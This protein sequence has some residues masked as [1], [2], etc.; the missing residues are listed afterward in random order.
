M[1]GIFV[2]CSSSDNAIA[3]YGEY[4]AELGRLIAGKGYN[5]VFGGSYNGLMGLVSRVAANGGSNVIAII[6]KAYANDTPEYCSEVISTETLSERKHKMIEKSASFIFLPGG[7]GSLDEIFTII[8]TKRAKE[9]NKSIIIVNINGY[10][11]DLIK[12]I[13]SIVSEGF[14][15][16]SDLQ[17]FY[18]TDNVESAVK[19]LEN[20]N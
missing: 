15:K 18:V 13:N 5:L 17:L 10:Y 9:H 11:D 16:E 14:A 7:I 4:A 12:Q 19:Y 3:K 1:K 6:S 8:E 2:G 20:Y